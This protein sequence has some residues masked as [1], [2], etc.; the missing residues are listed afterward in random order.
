M[1]Y[2]PARIEDIRIESK[3]VGTHLVA[4]IKDETSPIDSVE[5]EAIRVVKRARLFS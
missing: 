2:N 1:S 3:D 5:I 4:V